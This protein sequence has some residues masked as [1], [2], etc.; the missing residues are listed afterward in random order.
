MPITHIFAAVALTL[1]TSAAFAQTLPAHSAL[2][3]STSSAAD[4]TNV[5]KLEH[6]DA[7]LVDKAL[8]P[9]ND[10]YKYSCNKWL[11]ANPIPADQVYWST[12]SGLEL[13]NKGS[14]RDAGS[15]QQERSRPQS[16][17]AEDWR[18]LVRLHG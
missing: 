14:L 1:A 16:R 5:P 9:C 8:D 4:Q 15:S 2:P 18:L 6:F 10:F 12:G 13:W 17:S 11:T 7:D 3:A